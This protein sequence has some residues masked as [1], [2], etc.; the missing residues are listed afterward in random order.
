[1]QI[2]TNKQMVLTELNK[3]CETG[4]EMVGAAAEGHAVEYCPVDTGRLSG[5]LTHE[6]ESNRSMAVGTNVDYSVPVELGHK[7]QPGRY[8]PK[9]GKRLKADFVAARPFLRPA[10]ENHTD[11][12]TELLE[13]A[14]SGGE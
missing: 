12:Y 9:L 5:S 10:M 8:V 14:F 11:E 3:A 4:L 7:Q 2:I 13:K 6:A 1:M